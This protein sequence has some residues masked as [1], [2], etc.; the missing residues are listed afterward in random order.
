M[1]LLKQS[2]VPRGP[3]PTCGMPTS[4][5]FIH[6]EIL[7]F[8]VFPGLSQNTGLN[9][10]VRLPATNWVIIGSF[11]HLVSYLLTETWHLGT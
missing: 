1:S 9:C 8:D 6:K 5:R 3:S 4:Q 7:D 10:P 11:W 2:T